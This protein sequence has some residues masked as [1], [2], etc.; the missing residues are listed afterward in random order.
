MKTSV[1][2]FLFCLVF[3]LACGVSQQ[4]YDRVVAEKAAIAEEL[5]RK[6]TQHTCGS[7]SIWREKAQE[8][9]YASNETTYSIQEYQT[10]FH[11]AFIPLANVALPTID[12][13]PQSKLL[14]LMWEWRRQM[15]EYSSLLGR[16]TIIDKVEELRLDMNDTITTAS[17][18]LRS[19]CQLDPLVLYQSYPPKK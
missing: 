9:L 10:N 2:V 16:G 17:A 15:E 12:E 19:E 14:P 8:L 4:E 13:N 7:A 18:L 6:I 3:F 5:E 1:I 11:N